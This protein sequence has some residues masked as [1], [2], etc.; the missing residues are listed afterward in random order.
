[1]L[2]RY[3][4]NK[5]LAY[6]TRNRHVDISKFDFFNEEEN[7]SVRL[8]D[9]ANTTVKTSVENICDYVVIGHTRWFVSNYVYIN[10]GQVQL[11]L[12]RD[13]VGEF[14][15]DNCFGKIERGY[16][17]GILKYRKEL[18]LNEV[19]KKRIPIIPSSKTYGNIE[20]NTHDGE[21]WGIL[22]FTKDS[23]KGKV[24]I[25]IPAF[26]P[27]Y[28]MGTA[29]PD[30]S[31]YI[32]STKTNVFQNFI[33]RF[34]YVEDSYPYDI[35]CSINY[36][37]DNG[38]WTYDIKCSY[39]GIAPNVCLGLQVNAI[40][41]VDRAIEIARKFCE[42]VAQDTLRQNYT[43]YFTFPN[44]I[45]PDYNFPDYDG[46]VIKDGNDYYSYTATRDTSSDNGQYSRAGFVSYL[47]SI[48]SISMDNG[49][50]VTPT[51]AQDNG[52]LYLSSYI[53]MN[54]ITYNRTTL[55]RSTVGTIEV[56]MTT[57]L[58]DEPY[59]ILAF[60]LYDVTIKDNNENV[61]YV[62]QRHNAFMIFNE[63]I[64][65]L[66]GENGFL[67]DAQIYPY[68][69]DITKK[70]TQLV[71][72]DN[73]TYP[74][75]AINST[76]YTRKCNIQLLPYMDVKKEYLTRNYSIVSPEQSSKFSFNF[77]DYVNSFEG[78]GEYNNVEMEISVKTA[79]KPFA[80]ISSAVI[81]RVNSL[82]GENYVT[83]L[84]GSQP[85]SNGFECSLASNAFETYKRQN[86]NY[87]ALFGLEK[88][89]LAKQ[90]QVERVNESVQLMM[91]ILTAT[92]F[93]AI[94]GASIADAGLFSLFG[95]KAAGAAIGAGVSGGAV[96]I[97]SI[98]QGVENEKLR[99][100]EEYLQQQ[101]YDLT[102]GTIK[103]LP[104]T[105][106]RISSFNEIIMQE[107][108]YVLEVYE[109]TDE[110]KNI[111]D[112]FIKNYGYGLGVYDF[113]INYKRNGWFLKASIIKSSLPV[114]L[115]EILVTDLKGG[116]YIYE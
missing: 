116:V 100:Y 35:S 115:H 82:K 107:F 81:K 99:K 49:I 54:T 93:G 86:S 38:Q 92:S 108:Y 10:G 74:F 112:T 21:M 46:K 47:N 83:N 101:K 104:N 60:P 32:E 78:S 77:Y 30:G 88:E 73:T 33:A 15:L 17:D 85:S 18:S 16:T 87:Q 50:V 61:T 8:G 4:K 45:Y 114:N 68:C 72:G 5:D 71:S 55:D 59:V 26:A 58:V 7:R 96:G 89:E 20:V 52:G 57:Q 14:G 24:A 6:A 63:V 90:H 109:C 67:V 103:N 13:V 76:S 94:A 22:Y 11:N 66:S 75:F 48:G 42:R 36:K 62:I 56:D 91:N 29:I 113:A 51:N 53:S 41:N 111:V 106:S 98:I 43:T 110:E 28:E 31:T 84:E 12:Q 64:Q 19:L 95:T 79:L 2:I 1:M 102:L 9:G 70:Q 69:P 23:S 27:T 34:V 37:Y 3:Y 25:N 44:T 105:I 40:L 80:I 97:A 39:Y 65:G